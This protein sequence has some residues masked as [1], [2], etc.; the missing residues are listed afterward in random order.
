MTRRPSCTQ[1]RSHRPHAS[2]AP[3]PERRP[4]GECPVFMASG[5]TNHQCGAFNENTPPHGRGV[6]VVDCAG[7]GYVTVTCPS[8]A[9]KRGA[10][11]AVASVHGI[12]S[13]SIN[14]KLI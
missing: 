8:G 4:V 3:L 13:R 14:E 11:S 12:C 2:S 1:K 6:F 5:P 10:S 9:S 7:G